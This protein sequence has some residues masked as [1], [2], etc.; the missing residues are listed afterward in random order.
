VAQPEAVM[1]VDENS[2]VV[3]SFH[4]GSLARATSRTSDLRASCRRS[5]YA[6]RFERRARGRRRSTPAVG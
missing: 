6:A 3:E 1:A 2:R 5:R 4:D